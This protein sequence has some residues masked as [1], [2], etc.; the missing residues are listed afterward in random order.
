MSVA[1]GDSEPESEESSDDEEED[2]E[3]EDDE[4]DESPIENPQPATATMK[5]TVDTLV[6]L[7][8]RMDACR[9]RLL[10]RFPPG[11]K[12][13]PAETPTPPARTHI[14]PPVEPPTADAWAGAPHVAAA[15][16]T[17]LLDN[18][19]ADSHGHER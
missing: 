12:N 4:N 2:D 14:E 5:A 16:R 11:S 19:D 10:G 6:M 15:L 8:S 17:L 7:S 9:G 3:E 1:S 18:Y 13:P